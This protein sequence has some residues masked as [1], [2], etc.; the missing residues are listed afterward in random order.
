VGYVVVGMGVASLFLFNAM[1][2][3][4]VPRMASEPMGQ[5]ILVAAFV[6]FGTGI[7]LIRKAARIDT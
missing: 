6:L 2:P 7:F 3:G 1:S 5:A 4:A